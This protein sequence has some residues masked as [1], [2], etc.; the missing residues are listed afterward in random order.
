[1]AMVK[2]LLICSLLAFS[3]TLYAQD[4]RWADRVIDVSSQLG[5]TEN[6]ALNIL[7]APDAMQQGEGSP[8][9][10]S[11]A[12]DEDGQ[13]IHVAFREPIRVRQVV[14]AESANP[15]AVE[16]VTLYDAEGRELIST[17]SNIQPVQERSRILSIPVAMTPRAVASVKITL[18]AGR[19]E[20]RQAIDAIGISGSEEPYREQVNIAED[21]NF[22]Q[23]PD[24]LGAGVNSP[25]NEFGPIV[26]ADGKTLYFSRRFHPK[27]VGG[28]RDMEDIWF[29]TWDEQ[30]KAWSEARNMGEPMNNDL[31]NFVSSVTPD[32]NTLLLGNVYN[33]DGSMDAG[34]SI[35]RRTENGWTFPEKLN[36]INE[37]NVNKKVN[38]ALS[39]SGNILITS[40]ERPGDTRG[41][42]DLYVSFLQEDGRWSEPKSLGPVVNTN[43]ADYAPFLAADNRTLYYSTSGHTGFGGDD[44]FMTRRMG[45][46][47]DNWTTPENLGDKINTPKDDAYFTLPAS[48]EW[49]YYTSNSASGKDQDI[50]RINMPPAQRP[51][52]VVLVRGRVLNQDS[53]DPI[54]ASIVYQDLA[55][56]KEIGRATTSPVDG[57]FQI[58]LPSGVNYGYMAKSQGFIAVSDNMDLK[59]LNEYKEIEKD[60]LMS[61]ISAERKTEVVMTPDGEEKVEEVVA[62][63]KPI[64]MNNIFFDFNKATLRPESL[65]ELDR[66]VEVMKENEG[67]SIEVAG[68]TDDVGSAEYNQRLSKERAKAVE[69]YLESQGVPAKRVSS[70]GYGKAKPVAPNTTDEGRSQNRRVE[71]IIKD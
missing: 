49:A 56:G 27:N 66:F 48:G 1:M 34:V 46:G 44:I 36:I 59:E 31:Y 55:T 35:T 30:S 16:F 51:R 62:E 47:W 32:G 9:A 29:S 37:R 39:N 22:A 25:Y 19:V 26:S 4:I 50:Y 41:D 2:N 52:P 43:K 5:S 70:V 53:N 23:A 7:G 6:S 64:R 11:P 71:F 17:R 33:R 61:P 14:I 18:A 69:K 54:S 60:L 10:W 15:G 42:R 20:G 38:Y 21:I 67:L 57:M 58:V 24:R 3:S 28:K 68:H 63:R 45:E 65:P 12:V 13:F 8:N 40:A